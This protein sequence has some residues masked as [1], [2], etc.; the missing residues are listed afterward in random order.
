M[1]IRPKINDDGTSEAPRG[2]G[3]LTYPIETSMAATGGGGGLPIPTPG[4]INEICEKFSG[5]L[6]WI[7]Q[8]LGMRRT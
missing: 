2:M 1:Y 4:V 3:K 8:K 6:V 5:K 7:W